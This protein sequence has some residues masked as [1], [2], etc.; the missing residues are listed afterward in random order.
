MARKLLVFVAS[1]SEENLLDEGRHP[2]SLSLQN[3]Q[4]I[5][6]QPVIRCHIDNEA[7]IEAAQLKV[8]TCIGNIVEATREKRD[9]QPSRDP[10]II[11]NQERDPA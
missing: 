2:A 11:A 8:V 6:M 1:V 4:F 10:K 5:N 3:N 7:E 9:V